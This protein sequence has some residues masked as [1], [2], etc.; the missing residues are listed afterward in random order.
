MKKLRDM[1]HSVDYDLGHVKEI[2]I[3]EYIYIYKFEKLKPP[4]F[5]TRRDAK[6]WIQCNTSHWLFNLL[7]V[8]GF[9]NKAC[10]PKR[11]PLKIS[12]SFCPWQRVFMCPAV[13]F[14]S[15]AKRLVF[16]PS[17]LFPSLGRKK[18]GRE[19]RPNGNMY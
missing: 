10:L 4:S 16:L 15:S 5:A 1:R 3:Y 14:M 2:Y 11:P 7:S 9:Y 13:L 12:I 18:N 17:L 8:T 19:V 6:R